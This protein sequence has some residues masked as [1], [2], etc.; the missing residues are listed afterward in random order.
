[1]PCGVRKAKATPSG[2]EWLTWTAS[3]DTTLELDDVARLDLDVLDGAGRPT[4]RGRPHRTR[5]SAGCR[6]RSGTVEVAQQVGQRPMWSRCPWVRNTASMSS[7]RSRSHDQSGRIRSTPRCSASG[8]S[9]PTSTTSDATVDLDRGHVA[10]DL[11]E[12]SEEGDGDGGRRSRR[13]AGS[14]SVADQSSWASIAGGDRLARRRRA[15]GGPDRRAARGGERPLSGAGEGSANSA[16]CSGMQRRCS[17]RARA[18]S[19]GN[20]VD[21]LGDLRGP[22]GAALTETTPLAPTASSGRFT[23]SDPRPH[24]EPAGRPAVARPRRRPCRGRR[25]RP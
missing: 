25:W 16:R 10:A 15:A 17:S 4:P 5:A 2:I 21:H 18:G 7:A 14:S 22:P 20:A 19:V 12:P 9:T 24:P 8:N 6:R 11:A 23:S 13:A 3:T 1:M